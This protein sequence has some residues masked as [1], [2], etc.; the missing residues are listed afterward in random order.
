V[1]LKKKLYSRKQVDKIEE[2]SMKTTLEFVSENNAEN[3]KLQLSTIAYI[4]SADNY[5]EIFHWEED[6][7]KKV[8]LR[9]TLKH[10]ETQLRPY[11][12]FVRCHR[13]CIVNSKH[14]LKLNRQINNWWLTILN[15]DEKLPVS[16]QY[17]IP[18]KEAISVR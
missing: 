15:T 6:A 14:I 2:D 12:N 3:S 16:R 9:N 13:T 5:V 1:L 8:L 11:P 7:I 17:I 10:I 4:K 18:L